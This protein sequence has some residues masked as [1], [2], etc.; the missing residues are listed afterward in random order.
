MKRGVMGT[1]G[2]IISITFALGLIWK[3]VNSGDNISEAHRPVP[4][5]R[6]LQASVMDFA[7]RFWM[8]KTQCA[9][10]LDGKLRNNLVSLAA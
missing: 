9:V 7:L 10:S 6:A 1:Q 5:V 8:V 4:S 3:H 2:G